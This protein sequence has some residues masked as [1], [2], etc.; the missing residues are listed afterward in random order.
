ML[1]GFYT[2]R[3]FLDRR[4]ATALGKIGRNGTNPHRFRDVGPN[5][6]DAGIC[7]SGAEENLRFLAPE[8]AASSNSAFTFYRFL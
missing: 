4:A 3:A 6:S 8:Q 2:N 7:R 1:D 5:E